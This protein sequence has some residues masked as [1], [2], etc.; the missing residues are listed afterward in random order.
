MAKPAIKLMADYHCS[1]LWHHGS[2]EVGNIAPTEIG[3]SEGLAAKL[4]AWAD[5][6]DSHLNIG[7]PAA[8]SWTKEEELRFDAEGRALCREIDRE[9]GDRFAVVYSSRCIPIEAL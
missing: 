3:V 2:S 5:T 9:I 6:F 1:P 8:T 4:E 7:D